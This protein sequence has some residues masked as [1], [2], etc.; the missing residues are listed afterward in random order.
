[1]PFGPPSLRLR[2]S[3]RPGGCVD[4]DSTGPACNTPAVQVDTQNCAAQRVRAEQAVVGWSPR[5]WAGCERHSRQ[6]V[7]GGVIRH[8]PS[9]DRRG[10]G[11]GAA[12]SVRHGFTVPGGHGKTDRPSGLPEPHL[13]GIPLHTAQS[14]SCSLSHP[15]GLSTLKRE[16]AGTS[17]FPLQRTCLTDRRSAARVAFSRRCAARLGGTF[18]SAVTRTSWRPASWT[19]PCRSVPCG[20]IPFGSVA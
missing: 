20:P 19:V 14:V 16:S 3:A 13:I 7:S 12:G 9:G 1:M 2:Q 18:S 11:G 15:L 5:S 8:S 6:S 4:T 17:P 10:A